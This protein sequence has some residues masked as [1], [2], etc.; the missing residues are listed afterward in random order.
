MISARL[1]RIHSAA[2]AATASTAVEAVEAVEAWKK[3]LVQ[4]EA[5][6][7]VAIADQASIMIDA[8][9]DE[10]PRTW[11]DDILDQWIQEKFGA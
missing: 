8:M 3:V 9:S 6:G 2:T 10:P 4:A 7:A 5:E 1:M 11:E